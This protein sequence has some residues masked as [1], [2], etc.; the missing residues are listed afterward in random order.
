MRDRRRTGG[1]RNKIKKSVKTD[2]ATSKSRMCLQFDALKNKNKTTKNKCRVIVLRQ[3]I[4]KL[5]ERYF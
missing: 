3:F 1:E 2:E 4:G 5:P